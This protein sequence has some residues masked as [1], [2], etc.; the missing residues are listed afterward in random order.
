MKWKKGDI[1]KS[2]HSDAVHPIIFLEGCDDSF[3]IGAMI[4]SSSSKKY[5]DNIPMEE[6]HFLSNDKNG[7][8]YES[9]YGPSFLIEAKLLKKLEWQPFRKTGQLTDLGIEFV[10]STMQGKNPIT[11]EEYLL[12]SK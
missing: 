3:F 1:L 4:T 9:R 11:W 12:T 10:Y 5:P 6:I 8:I 2:Q 7:K